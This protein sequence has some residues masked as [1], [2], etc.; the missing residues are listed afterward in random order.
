LSPFAKNMRMGTTTT[1]EGKMSPT[2]KIED[3]ECRESLAIQTAADCGLEDDVLR[4]AQTF[5]RQNITTAKNSISVR[6]GDMSSSPPVV[7]SS[8][9]EKNRNSGIS[10]L[11][12]GLLTARSFILAEEGEKDEED[13]AGV[14]VVLRNEHPP[15]KVAHGCSVV[16]VIRDASGWTYVGETESIANRLNSHRHKYGSDI[17]CAFVTVAQGKS[18]ARAIETATIREFRRKGVPLKSDFDASHENFGGLSS[19]NSSISSSSNTTR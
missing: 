12:S 18:T 10:D 17:D 2:W 4:R 6:K 11:A 15:A 1:P 9:V 3:G 7:S 5:L 19:R 14:F 13:A 16:Y 8:K